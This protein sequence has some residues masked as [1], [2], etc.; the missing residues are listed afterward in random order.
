[1]A[2]MNRRMLGNM[3][4]ITNTAFVAPL[5]VT[6][7]KTRFPFTAKVYPLS[8]AGFQALGLGWLAGQMSL[9]DLY[10]I[11]HLTITWVP[12]LSDHS[13]GSICFYFDPDPTATPPNSFAALSGNAGLRTAKATRSSALNVPGSRMN[14]LPWY[15]CNG[16]GT[17]GTVGN[18]V[19]AITEGNIP[20]ADTGSISVGYFNIKYSVTLK[21]PT[22]SKG[23]SAA[24][25]ADL[26]EQSILDR[27]DD[28]IEHERKILAKLEEIRQSLASGAAADPAMIA[29]LDSVINKMVTKEVVQGI[30][31]ELSTH[32]RNMDFLKEK[33][34]HCTTNYKPGSGA[35]HE[36]FETLPQGT[37]TIRAGVVPPVVESLQQELLKATKHLRPEDSD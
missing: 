35:K 12:S 21:N 23:T 11:D 27:E 15:Q 30:S 17:E 29:K 26:I 22:N 18:L 32:A 13:S 24:H 8:K 1:M 20:L 3:H 25:G 28:I 2:N 16:N 5:S 34:W 36:A 4:S 37:R 19:V 9:Y 7:T 10:R 14:R 6:V 31:G 33:V